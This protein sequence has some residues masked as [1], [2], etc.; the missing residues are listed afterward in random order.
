MRSVLARL[1]TFNQGILIIN[2]EMERLELL[3]SDLIDFN[4]YNKNSL[5]ISKQNNDLKAF[6]LDMAAMY[7][8]Y[9]IRVSYS[10]NEYNLRFDIDRMKQVFHNLIQNSIKFRGSSLV[11]IEIDLS[12][13][14]EYYVIKYRDYGTEMTLDE[15]HHMFDKFYKGNKV[16]P[17][18]GL[19]LYVVKEIIQA[20]KGRNR[21]IYVDKGI[22]LVILLPINV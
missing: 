21:G 4:K 2:S 16:M 14:N 1:S 17:G 15:V 3:I 18:V 10:Q 12:T 9:D 20:H 8:K 19:G 13:E 11:K 6:L 5:Q 7:Q 22:S